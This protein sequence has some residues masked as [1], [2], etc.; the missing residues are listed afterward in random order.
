MGR[1]FAGPA[2]YPLHS[3][4]TSFW[5]V[6]QTT[7]SIDVTSALRVGSNIIA[8]QVN[9]ETY[10]TVCSISATLTVDGSTV[11]PSNGVWKYLPGLHEPSGGVIDSL[12]YV[13]EISTVGTTAQTPGGLS[14][15]PLDP[16]YHTEAIL[17]YMPWVELY[18]DG[19]E[20]LFFAGYYLT[21]SPDRPRQ[22]EIPIGLLDPGQAMIF[23]TSGSGSIFEY[24]HTNFET[25]P[26]TGYAPFV[27]L[28]S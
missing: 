28:T 11:I 7:V 4:Q 16:T 12:Y 2:G 18:N 17:E 19:A 20:S 6:G 3:E 14:S 15:V 21:N 10:Q 13:Y 8:I 9:K 5:A 23:I 1:A 24:T 26:Y 27:R 22:F 25:D